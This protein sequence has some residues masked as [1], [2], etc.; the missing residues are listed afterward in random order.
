M[1]QC[2]IGKL[3]ILLCYLAFSHAL[4]AQQEL[5]Q[6]FGFENGQT[7]PFDLGALNGTL[8]IETDPN[9]VFSGTYSLK[10]NSLP[11]AIESY[12]L[13]WLG[14]NVVQV[15]SPGTY[16]VT[17][18]VKANKVNTQ[19]Q[20]HL[21]G[22]AE[23]SL[24]PIAN[25]HEKT[26]ALIGLEWQEITVRLNIP[27]AASWPNAALRLDHDGN[28]VATVWW[29]NVSFHKAASAFPAAPG[30]VSHTA[31]QTG[32]WDSPSTWS[33]GTVPDHG[34]IVNIPQG[35]TVTVRTEVD[36]Q[37]KFL[38]VMGTLAC[39]PTVNTSLSFETMVIGSDGYFH[40][41][42]ASQAV[43]ADKTA[44][45]TIVN[46]GSPIDLVWDSQERSRGIF[47]PGK[48][49]LFGAPKT[50]MTTLTG[51]VLA[52]ASVL[53]LTSAPSGWRDGD[54]LVV[55][56]TQ[57]RRGQDLE[58]DLVG[59]SNNGINGSQITLDK[60]LDHDHVAYGQYPIHVANI[61]RNITIQS[62]STEIPKRGHIMFRSK[63]V[64][65]ENA[66][67]I[68]LGRTDK[69]IPLDEIIVEIGFDDE[70]VDVHRILPN[71]DIK[72]RRG[73]YP[74]HFHILGAD[75]NETVIPEVKGSVVHGT[76]GWGFVN[77]SS[78]IDF[79]E[80]VAYDF[81]GSG[82]VTES[83]DELGSFINNI[84]IRGTGVPNEYFPDR[85]VFEKPERPQPLGDFG[86]GGDG[87]W[88]QGPALTVLNN[89][90]SSCNG[91]GMFW[92]G[93]GAVDI[94]TEKYVGF[95]P[96]YIPLVYG[97]FPDY[98][99]TTFQY[100]NW[101]D[102]DPLTGQITILDAVIADLPILE[103][104][105]FQAYGCLVGLHNRF[106]NHLSDSFYNEAHFK[107]HLQYIGDGPSQYLEQTPA[108]I[109]LWNNETG[110]RLRYVNQT[111][112]TNVNIHNDRDYFDEHMRV[113]G[114]ETIVFMLNQKFNNLDVD[115]YEVAAQY[116]TTQTDIDFGPESAMS[117]HNFVSK[118]VYGGRTGCAQVGNVANGAPTSSSVD[119]SWGNPSSSGYQRFLVR[120][121][122]V[123]R[124]GWSFEEIDDQN[125]TGVMLASLDAGTTYEYQVI[126]RC[127]ERYD[128]WSPKQTFTTL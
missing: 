2:A 122:P 63:E 115:G 50:H 42:T 18:R 26:T 66:A 28:S 69:R 40:I 119:I 20:L 47:S 54:Q 106:Q 27:D 98:D 97:H 112:W 59:I 43:A 61:T 100:R 117:F 88:F 4:F 91:A 14:S 7:D 113:V 48:F 24:A 19:V 79:K 86:F 6:N 85:Q 118:H 126:A 15:S 34:S 45:L 110:M 25:L 127:T 67:F 39:D 128:F 52:S 21:F 104:S 96:E 73:R 13:P 120:Y 116:D 58:D 38:R 31:Q 41:G 29:D 65:I 75:P 101:T 125:S 1:K 30:P 70:G 53:N 46:N 16:Q 10:H 87:F 90:A 105:G 8:A 95:K 107:Y 114:L 3:P 99:S 94:T 57:F 77:H 72:N 93:T 36:A 81:A 62:E 108:T 68:D 35:S 55:A 51:D 12:T 9:N 89:V 82:F 17:A 56:G 33:S 103:F 22:L 49:H 32:F 11:G 44:T 83:G 78:Y 76:P 102:K 109:D 124:L 23:V 71:P 37:L 5:I 121:R 92:F 74:V 80:N 111:D 60:S 84:A 64:T 123:G